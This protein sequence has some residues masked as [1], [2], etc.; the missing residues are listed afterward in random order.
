MKNLKTIFA[1]LLMAVLSIGQVWGLTNT[2]TKIT[3]ATSLDESAE[4]VIGDVDNYGCP[5]NTGGTAI[6]TTEA[7]WVHWNAKNVDGGFYLYNGAVYL[8]VPASNAWEAE[9]HRIVLC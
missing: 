8:K 3:S 9:H 1:C 6:N 5:T 2:Y 7:S 4:Y